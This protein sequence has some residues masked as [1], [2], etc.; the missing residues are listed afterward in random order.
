MNAGQ[1][2][3]A[4]RYRLEERIGSGAMGVVWRARDE[5][6]DRIVAVK[7]LLLTPGL[8]PQEA[9]VSRARA[10]REG[11]IAARLQHPHAISVFDVALGSTGDGNDGNSGDDGDP[12]LVMEYLPS[13]SLAAVLAERGPLPAREVARIGRDMADALTAAH[14]AGIVHRDV[15]PGNVLLAAD[16][17][18]KITDFGIS[19]AAGDVTVTRT[20]VLAGTPAYFAPEV[21]RGEPPGPASDVFS[22]GSTLYTAVEGGPPFGLDENTLALLR[23]VADGRVQPPRQAGPLSALLMQ[24]L[25]SDPSQR[26]SMLQARQSLAAVAAG[27]NEHPTTVL[28]T[29]PAPPAPGPDRP[30]ASPWW[31]RR[32]VVPAAAAV[33]L[34]VAGWIAL[35]TLGGR[36][37]ER[38]TTAPAP[39]EQRTAAQQPPPAPAPTTTDPGPTTTA[40]PPRPQQFE[41][42]VRAYYRLLPGNTGAAWEYLGDG[43]RWQADG[44]AGYEQFWSGIDNVRIDGPPRVD[45]NVVLIDLRFD[46]ERGRSSYERYRL[47]MSTRP[48]GDAVIQTSERIGSYDPG[49]NRGS[50]GQGGGRDDD[51]RDN[52]SN[53]SNG[54]NGNSNG[55]G[56]DERDDDG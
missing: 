33:L 38:T 50:S 22:L 34:V 26:P 39:S 18:V 21:A 32:A 8:S 3:I 48:D 13:A 37:D 41:R 49:G 54:G 53:S 28:A 17:T 40:P 9:E 25:H 44:R 5:R 15:K 47:T 10:M 55:N 52:S 46:P 36:D 30:A 11:R 31:Q 7:Q 23:A 14:R 2:L 4:Q 24:L 19:R 12:W 45:R 16:G 51:D 20:G 56:G 29:A 43:V 6:L 35:A 42:T 1:R 27:G